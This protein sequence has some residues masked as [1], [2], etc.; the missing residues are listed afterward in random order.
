MAT[1]RTCLIAATLAGPLTGSALASRAY[2]VTAHSGAPVHAMTHEHRADRARTLRP[3]VAV[4]NR[5]HVPQHQLVEVRVNKTTIYLDKQADYQYQNGYGIDQNHSLLRAQRLARALDGQPVT[6]VRN[7]HLPHPD[8]SDLQV[9]DIQ[10]RAIFS[11]PPR[12]PAPRQQDEPAAP[13]GRLPQTAS[14]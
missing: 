7:E 6:V 8:A 5:V 12:S 14:R 2:V 1:I 11:A 10:P 3:T 13:K 9:H 4:V